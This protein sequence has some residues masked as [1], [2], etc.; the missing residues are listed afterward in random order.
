MYPVTWGLP[1]LNMT[2][3][4]NHLIYVTVSIGMKF[5]ENLRYYHDIM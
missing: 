5:P 3:P 1:S 4:G 2:S